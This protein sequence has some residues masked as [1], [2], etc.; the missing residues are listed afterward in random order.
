MYQGKAPGRRFEIN[1]LGS[2][3]RKSNAIF[4]SGFSVSLIIKRQFTP[5][6]FTLRRLLLLY[7]AE[8][9]GF[10]WIGNFF[11]VQ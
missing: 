3:G 9:S 6:L 8:L 7:R 4:I 2:V 5:M 11:S 1:R 10:H